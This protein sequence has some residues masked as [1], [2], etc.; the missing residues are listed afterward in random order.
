MDPF[1]GPM[2]VLGIVFLVGGLIA[3]LG[4][5]LDESG[6]SEAAKVPMMLGAAIM[7]V[8]V[9]GVFG[10]VLGTLIEYLV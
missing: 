4:G 1:W 5:W 6:H 8:A 7:G 10:K 3:G 2:M 9:V